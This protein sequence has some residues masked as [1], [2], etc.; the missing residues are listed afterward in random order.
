MSTAGKRDANAMGETD[1]DTTA[2][3]DTTSTGSS[4]TSSSATA[5]SPL[6]GDLPI[7]DRPIIRRQR[8]MSDSHLQSPRTAVRERNPLNFRNHTTTNG[9]TGEEAEPLRDTASAI[10]DP[11]EAEIFKI[12]LTGGPCAGKTTV[13]SRLKH[14][15]LSRGFR[16]FIAPEAATMLFSGGV[17]FSDIATDEGKITFQRNLLKTQMHLEDSLRDLAKFTRKPSVILCD[18]G[19]MDGKAYVSNKVWN[20]VLGAV[21][22]DNVALRDT[23]YNAVLHMVTAAIGAEQF[24]TAEN[25]AA[26]TETKEEA[27]EQDKKTMQ[28]WVGH[29]KVCA[30]V[31]SNR[32]FRLFARTF[33]SVSRCVLCIV[34]VTPRI[35][36]RFAGHRLRQLDSI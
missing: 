31:V 19:A 20:E 29:P 34:C 9:N 32:F 18:R 3:A 1:K 24:Y 15:L 12:V 5:P 35:F 33:G 2:T 21:Q 8:S 16:V 10:I 30:C 14:F 7:F 36:L 25:N 17:M 28:C 13:M 6:S 4:S 11:A 26:R 23:R 22:S 27:A